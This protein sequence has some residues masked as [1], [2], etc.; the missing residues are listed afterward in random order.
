[1]GIARAKVGLVYLAQLF[2]D[3]GYLNCFIVAQGI[4]EDAEII[5]GEYDPTTGDFYIDF[6]H[7]DF[8]DFEDFDI[9]VQDIGSS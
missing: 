2:T 3:D 5:N 6:E 8:K 7:P 9:I 1:M 4:P